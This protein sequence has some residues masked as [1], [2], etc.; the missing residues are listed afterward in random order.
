MAA[1][2]W[3]ARPA[4]LTAPDQEQPRLNQAAPLPDPAAP[5][6]QS[7]IAAHNG[8]SAVELL[9]VVYAGAPA[10]AALTVSVVGPLG[11]LVAR[12]TFTAVKHNAPL[13]LTFA[14]EPDSAGQTYTVRLEGA[15][16][17]QVTAWAHSLDVYARGD[18]RAG[19]QLVPGDLRFTTTY[20]RL[21]RDLA[22][23]SAG[24]LADLA[25][26]AMPLWLVVFAPGVLVLDLTR[27][28][29][30][31]PD[32]WARWGLAL[33]LSLA[34]L[35]LAWQWVT[36][37]GL[38]LPSL[39]L[40]AVYI[41][42]GAVVVVRALRAAWAARGEW[43]RPSATA[44]LLTG[45]LGVG[46]VARLLA[47]QAL[48]L[49]A[50][51]DSA[52]HYVIARLL[53]ETGRVPANYAPLLPVD[54]FTYHFGVHAAVVAFHR[55][56]A[57]PLAEAF[58]FLGQVLNGLMPLA[59]YALVVIAT[60]RPGAG[61]A[62][63]FCVGW[64][65][66]FPA[67][68]LS[69][70][71]YT[72]L[73]GLLVLAPLLGLVWRA[74]APDSAAT[75]SSRTP[76]NV[77]GWASL[78]AGGLALVHYRV[79]AFFATYVWAALAAGRRGGWRRALL[80]GTAAVLAAAPWL[81]R[82]GERWIVPTVQAP[83]AVI[84]P[85]GYNDF[86]VGYFTSL[87]ERGWIG[88]ALLSLAWGLWRRERWL[89]AMAGW[90]AVTLALLNLGSGSWLV[91]NNAWAISL[92]VPG[93]A[94]AGWGC[95]EAWSGLTRWRRAPGLL[96]PVAGALLTAAGAG[97]LAYAGSLGLR[98]Q[99]ATLNATTVLTTP[100][101][102]DALHWVAANTPPEAVFVVNSWLWQ[103][104]VYAGPDGGYWVWPYTSRRTTMPP[105]DYTYQPAWEAEVR[106]FNE[107]LAR[108][109]DANAPE[110]LAL[111][112]AAGATHVFIGARGGG[113]KPEWFVDSPN[114]D[115]LYSNGADWVFA[116]RAP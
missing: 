84:S 12:E 81:W 2:L 30:W 5:V 8:F 6:A 39:A 106:A 110:T 104:S 91:N 1:G 75:Q 36:W 22:L 43:A 93:A 62:A 28:R 47:A 52:H 15:T 58:L 86:P 65:S 41:L 108:V 71:R 113:L 23:D 70:G 25:L 90:I 24:A 16:A 19:Q 80:L 103:T 9:A 115:L 37:L 42:I 18:L 7:L 66:L 10:D 44:V 20:T 68:Y 17:G 100:D 96:R 38:A 48:T 83:A 112:R 85:A 63:A 46:L 109:K 34:L 72:Q 61:L 111:W 99:V 57:L 33:A 32:A 82:L 4:P 54:T 40:N 92:F 49:P 95:A 35:P 29:R 45:V 13:R 55:L 67:Y 60:G 14:P 74:V 27:A 79:L 101:D 56:T 77:L 69:W 3:W 97:L 102:L 76:W 31:L 73:A 21:W 105:V 87:L 89:W 78:L 59:L 51:V 64:L 116:I 98:A 88:A 114:Y 50:W 107:R 94:L 11:R 53:D 26:S